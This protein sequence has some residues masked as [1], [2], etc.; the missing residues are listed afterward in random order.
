M[1]LQFLHQFGFAVANADGIYEIPFLDRISIVFIIAL[2]GMFFISIYENR[3]GVKVNALEVDKRMF[4][5]SPSF[6]V[7]SLLAL[8]ILSALYTIFW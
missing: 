6:I 4:K 7:G 5:M 3:K 1:D 8:G 2:A